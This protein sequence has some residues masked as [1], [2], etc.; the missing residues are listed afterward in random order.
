MKKPTLILAEDHPQVSDQ[1]VLLLQES[2]VVWVVRD[3][4]ALIRLV[5]QLHPDAIVSDII[6][7]GLDGIRATKH[8]RRR[9]PD[10]PIV[11]ISVDCDDDLREAALAAGAS[12]FV[13]KREMGRHLVRVLLNLLRL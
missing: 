9:Y 5:D 3:G 8:I 6:L 13:C 2:F 10:A 12:E 11:L 7:D 4:S 1:I